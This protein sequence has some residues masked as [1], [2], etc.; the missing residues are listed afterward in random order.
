M[1]RIAPSDNLDDLDVLRDNSTAGSGHPHS[2]S[3]K[4]PGTNKSG[5]SDAAVKIAHVKREVADT[6]VWGMIFGRRAPP[7]LPWERLS[8]SATMQRICWRS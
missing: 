4:R 6:G 7:P 1:P 5:G 8:S 2:P 3:D